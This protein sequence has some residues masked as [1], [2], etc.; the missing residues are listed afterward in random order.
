MRRKLVPISHGRI[1]VGGVTDVRSLI[2]AASRRYGLVGIAAAVVECG[3]T[4][5][6]ECVGIADRAG[7]AIDTDSIFGIASITKTITA[8]AVMQLRDEGRFQLDDPVNKYLSNLVVKAPPGAPDVTIRHLLTHTGG[9]G[10]VPR[11]R[12]LVRREIW[13][14]GRPNAAPA[15]VSAIY[16]GVLRT[17]VPAAT[18]WAYANHGFAVLGKLVEDVS[19]QSFADYT[20]QRIFDPLGMT[21]TDAVRSTRVSEGR[22]D[23]SHWLLGRFRWVNDYDVTLMGPGSV[24]STVDDLAKYATSLLDAKPVLGE[25]TTPQF[26]LDARLPTTMG[27]GFF[28]DDFEGHTVCGHD[29]NNPGFASA[30]WIAPD[31]GV[32]VVAVTNTSTML[33]MHLLAQKVLRAELGVR[34]ATSLAETS[35]P[36]RPSFWRELSGHYAPQSGSLTNFRTWQMLGGEVQVFVRDRRLFMRALSPIPQLRRGV[37]LRAIDAE[38]PLLFALKIEGLVVPVAFARS[39][40]AIDRLA[41]GAPTMV[42]LHRRD[43]RRSS[44]RRLQVAAASSVGALAIRGVR[45]SHSR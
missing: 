10:E 30:L 36:A 4:P 14:A 34:D 45:R 12:D 17:E 26:S 40:D 16:G 3:T 23:P 31:D 28:L 7:H 24:V 32:G 25:M 35:A 41:I 38:D 2:E 18:K 21:K 43:G 5:R 33:G 27:L 29:G 13:G 42:Q 19:G 6:F 20:R 9:I 11:V 44:R 37:E 22:A 39:D 1:I 8:M 15:D